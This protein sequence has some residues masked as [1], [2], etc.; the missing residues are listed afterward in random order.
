MK[1]AK[2]PPFFQSIFWDTRLTNIDYK[3]HSRYVI[4]RVL[5][6]GR[7][8]HVRWM[9]RH[10][11]KRVILTVAKNGREVYPE[12]KYFWQFYLKNQQKNRTRIYV[13]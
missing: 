8:Q 1:A 9:L 12:R 5:Q 10:Y 13:H 3:K 2:L 11:S 4:E 6:W 7:P